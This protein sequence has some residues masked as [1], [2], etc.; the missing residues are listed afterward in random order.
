MTPVERTMKRD[1]KSAPILRK[2]GIGY[3]Y[4]Q[5][6]GSIRGNV[7]FGALIRSR[8]S[9]TLGRDRED[10]GDPVHCRS[11][12]DLDGARSAGVARGRRI[13]RFEEM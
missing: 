9:Y 10:R 6:L 13:R 3:L 4:G 7:S 1:H 5:V 8:C 11:G 12:L 2:W